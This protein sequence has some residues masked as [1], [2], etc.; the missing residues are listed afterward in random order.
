M[1]VW[2]V[3]HRELFI[4]QHED[5]GS[6]FPSDS[7]NEEESDSEEEENSKTEPVFIPEVKKRKRRSISQPKEAKKGS[8]GKKSCSKN[9]TKKRESKD[10]WSAE[11]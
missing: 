6:Q 7:S 11:R 9:K 8:R 3:H 2:G 1:E 5:D 10:R 4:R